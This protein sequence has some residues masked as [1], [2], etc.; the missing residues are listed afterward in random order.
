V[1]A[2]V[3]EARAQASRRN[4]ARSR[5]PR[6]P[7][8]KAAASRNAVKHG[9][10][11]V[12]GIGNGPLP[13]EAAALAASLA[14]LD[15]GRGENAGDVDVAV[16]AQ[17]H[18]E[19]AQALVA[20]LDAAIAELLGDATA[21]DARFDALSLQRLRMARYLRRFRGRRDRALRRIVGRCGPGLGQAVQTG[22]L[23]S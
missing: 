2:P 17:A 3:S 4:G 9:L 16:G 23:D 21:A 12:G 11:S 22:D 14:H 8:G 7:G 18:L 15:D 13:P 20:Q 19:A 1:T 6:T 10:F 5:G